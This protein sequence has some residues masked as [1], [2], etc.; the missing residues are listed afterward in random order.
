MRIV[1]ITGGIGTGKSFILRQVAQLGFPT[2]SADQRAKELMEQDPALRQGILAL[3]GEEAYTPSG[4]L[5]RPYIAEK[6]FQAPELRQKLNQLVHPRTIADFMD[7]IQA[8]R[9]EGHP[10][11]FKEAALTLE[12]GGRRGLDALLL[13]YAPLK[14]R[15]ERLRQRDKLTEMEILQRMNA[16]WP[17]WKKIAYADFLII[18][19]G[20]LPLRPQLQRFFEAW[21]IPFPATFA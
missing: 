9:A 2:Y 5:R 18:N 6:I 4:E 13:V 7:W 21:N 15:I 3:F 17:E 12:A 14:V 20:H 11:V 8:R 10:A 16:Q 19:D 1:G